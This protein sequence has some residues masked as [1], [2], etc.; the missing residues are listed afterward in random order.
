[1]LLTRFV[2]LKPPSLEV[3]EA[4]LRD[5]GTETEESLSKVKVIIT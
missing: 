4:R 2:F 3:L 1:M 5:R